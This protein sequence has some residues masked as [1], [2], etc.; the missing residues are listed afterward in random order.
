MFFSFLS[1]SAFLDS[2]PMEINKRVIR[3]ISYLFFFLLLGSG[4]QQLVQAPPKR[5]MYPDLNYR[6]ITLPDRTF[7][8]QILNKNTVFI[9]QPHVPG[10]PAK[11]GFKTRSRAETMARVV[12][13]KI[14]EGEIPPS[15]S[16]AEMKKLKV[17]D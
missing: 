1:G 2:Q 6:I 16:I 9:D 8:Y 3:A 5:H 4:F 11:T 15:V 17:L 14:K 13:G 7:G 10:L 12:I